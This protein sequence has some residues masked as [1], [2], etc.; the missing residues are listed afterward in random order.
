MS[1]GD[2]DVVRN[3]Y[4]AFNKDGSEGTLNFLHSDVVWDESTL[5]ARR[6]GIYRGHEGVLRLG[7]E[8]AELWKDIRV[9]IDELIDAGPG[10]V[11]ASVRVRGHG[12]H[13]GQEVELAMSQVWWIRDGKGHQVKLYLDSQEAI[14][15]AGTA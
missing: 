2:V 5:P 7:R 6:P 3:A 8:N 14:E 1:P 12:R 10:V 15:A 11:V 4:E 13:T 9:D